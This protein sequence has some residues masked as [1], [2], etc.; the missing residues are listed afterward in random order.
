MKLF[1]SVKQTK[2]N[3]NLLATS[4]DCYTIIRTS[5]QNFKNTEFNLQHK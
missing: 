2:Y 4:F 5:L 3:F 1:A